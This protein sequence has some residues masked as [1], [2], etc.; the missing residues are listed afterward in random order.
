MGVPAENSP[1]TQV[2]QP[3]IR[4]YLNPAYW[5]GVPLGRDADNQ[6][7]R[8]R[9]IGYRSEVA[10]HSG[11]GKAL[12]YL[13][14]R[15]SYPLRKYAPGDTFSAFE[16]E[17]GTIVSM[18]LESLAGREPVSAEELEECSKLPLPQRPVSTDFSIPYIGDSEFP[19][20]ST[21]DFYDTFVRDGDR[22][23][24]NSV[25]LG[26][27]SKT[28][29]GRKTLTAFPSAMFYR[30]ASGV[31]IDPRLIPATQQPVVEVGKVTQHYNTNARA[32]SLRR[33]NIMEL[34]QRGTASK[35]PKFSLSLVMAGTPS[36][37]QPS[38][39]A[40]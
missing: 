10:L 8:G 9:K 15:P 23:Y 26:V 37:L 36:A 4:H 11:L 39:D 16:H 12:S 21:A 7:E 32:H 1:E 33:V 13:R 25:L 5:D 27:V 18:R 29:R 28:G 2:G 24:T 31:T 6:A 40:V 20:L 19:E 30:R 22:Y 3:D 38:P 35:L 14:N 34:T 17:P